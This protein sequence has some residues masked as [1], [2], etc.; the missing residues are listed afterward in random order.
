MDT[1]QQAQWQRL[2]GELGSPPPEGLHAL[3]AA[4]LCA[5]ADTLARSRSRQRKNLSAALE[6]ALS[7]VPAL[8]RG[9]VRRILFP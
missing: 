6:H 4:E 2:T 3:S 8:V 5:W 7:F 1:E 9:A